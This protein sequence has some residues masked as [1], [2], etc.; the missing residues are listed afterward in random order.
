MKVPQIDLVHTEP[1]ERPVERLGHVLG[2]GTDAHAGR[3]AISI[4]DE[5]E[6]RRKEDLIPIPG[7]FEPESA[8]C[9]DVHGN[10]GSMLVDSPLADEVLTIE[11]HIGCI[12]VGATE[13][14]HSIQELIGLR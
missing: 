10:T 11:V 4:H 1:L 12:P 5:A 2:I 8:R 13:L 7:P 14:V 6:L 9:A 3:V